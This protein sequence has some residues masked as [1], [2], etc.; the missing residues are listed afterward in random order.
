VKEYEGRF[1]SFLQS[2]NSEEEFSFPYPFARGA[3]MVH[4]VFVKVLNNCVLI[5][6]KERVA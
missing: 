5:V 3:V 1:R 6:S 2:P 4:I